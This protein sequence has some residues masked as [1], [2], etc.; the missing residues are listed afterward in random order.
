MSKDRSNFYV[1]AYTK[2]VPGEGM[3]WLGY[4]RVR[5]QQL[6]KRRGPILTVVDM[7]EVPDQHLIDR[8]IL[9]DSPWRSK[10]VESGAD[11][12]VDYDGYYRKDLAR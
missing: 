12:A 2:T 10:F 4:G 5:F 6:V 1:R 9:G 7:E 8:G 3:R 11:F